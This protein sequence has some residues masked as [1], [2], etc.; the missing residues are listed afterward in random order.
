[1]SKILILGQTGSG[2]STSIGAIPEL[3][4][5]GLK[6]EETFIISCTNK[7]LPFKG[8]DKMYPI[9]TPKEGR[10]YITNN[11]L[12]ISKAIQ[13]INAGRPDIRTIVID[14]LNYVL[15]DDYMQNAMKGGYDVFKKMGYEFGSIF[16]AMEGVRADLDF[17]CMA[18]F[19][20]YRANS[21]DGISYRFKTVGKMVNDYLTPEG[22]FEIVLYCK[23][24]IDDEKKMTKSFVTNFDGI[25][26]AKS[27]IGMFS[28]VVIPN[29][30]GYVLDKV[31]EYYS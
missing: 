4:H 9:G 24:E 3:G 21:F 29:D 15:Q 30:L 28:D 5:K 13:F 18:H 19:E 8:S 31:H 22:K 25:Y 2:K 23:Q 11:G 27:P 20:E 1:M 26:P 12:N 16:L 6:P 10:R 14:D 7:P 17:I